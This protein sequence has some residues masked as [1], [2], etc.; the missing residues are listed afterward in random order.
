MPA[1]VRYHQHVLQAVGHRV[2]P[3]QPRSAA[4]WL[5]SESCLTRRLPTSASPAPLPAP[6]GR[7]Q[8]GP[9][10]HPRAAVQG[11]HQ[12]HRR[13]PPPEDLHPRSGPVSSS[14]SVGAPPGAACSSSSSSFGG[15]GS[16]GVGSR[17]RW[18]RLATAAAQQRAGV[19]SVAAGHAVVGRS[20]SRQPCAA[21][22]TCAAALV[23][24]WQGVQATL[25]GPVTA[26]WHRVLSS[27]RSHGTGSE[28]RLG[29][30]ILLLVLVV[31][32]CHSALEQR[33]SSGFYLQS[34]VLQCAHTATPLTMATPPPTHMR[35]T[36]LKTRHR[37][38]PAQ[39]YLGSTLNIMH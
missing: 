6:V 31:P 10:R 33:A 20:M 4:W 3:L 16:G 34:L 17:H 22:A 37:P 21:L 18:R 19:S 39:R 8:P 15:V 12:A 11:P 27:T 35:N 26:V 36:P 38:G 28:R 7:W 23:S 29:Q 9:R 2:V 1:A 30:R 5:L 13:E 14:S 32:W 25:T 24:S